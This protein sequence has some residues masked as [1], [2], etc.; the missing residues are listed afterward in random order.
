MAHKANFVLVL[1]KFTKT[2]QFSRYAMILLLATTLQLSAR[3]N[4]KAQIT[5]SET[6]AP[7][8]KIFNDIWKQTK[9]Q[10]V[11]TDK[12]L[13]N[14]NPVTIHVK[15]AALED[16]LDICFK[17]Q[18]FTY[19]ITD[20]A[21]VV[22]RKATI[23]APTMTDAAVLPVSEVRGF[24]TDTT[25][26]G[27]ENVAVRI[28]G[29]TRGTLTG[30]LGE[31]SL[32]N[33]PNDAVLE[34][35]YIGMKTQDVP[36]NSRSNISVTL[37]VQSTDLNDVVI[38]GYG[39]QRKINI[40]GAVGTITGKELTQIPVSNVSSM[41]LGTVS[42]ITGVQASGEPGR[43]SASIYIRGV[44]TYGSQT[45]LV[46]IDGVQQPEE[47]A[48]NEMNNMDAND[49]ATVSILKDASATAV[50]GIRGANGVIIITTKRGAVGKPTLSLSV[51][52]GFTQAA[53]LMK[54]VNSYE[55]ALM[56]NQ[57]IK[58]QAKDFGDNS[59]LAYLFSN[60]D[61]WKFQHNRD[62]TP[63][64][65]SAMNLTD[66]QKAQLNAS[67][68]IYY[69]SVD[70]MQEEFGGTGPQQQYNLN[71][72][73]GTDH[74]KYYTSLGYFGQGSI[75]NN[76]NYAGSNTGSSFSRYN[77]RSN[78]DINVTRDL[79]VSVNMTGE[80]GTTSGPG[81][82]STASTGPYD[83]TNRYKA[84]MQYIFD[85]NPFYSPGLIDGH[86]INYFEGSPGTYANPLGLK[87]GASIG[88]QNPIY[89]LL[90][91]GSEKLYST[92]LSSTVTVKYDLQ[93]VT[94]G[95]SA[96][97]STNYQG[98]YVKSVSYYPSLPVY[99]V[100]R[101]QENPNNLDFFNGAVGANN[102]N[103]NPGHNS[104]WYKMYYEGGL[105]YNRKFGSHTVS[106]LLLGTAQKYSM[107]SDA[108]NTPSGLM[109][110]VG[111]VTYNYKERYLAEANIGYNGTEQF[112]PGHRFGFFPA[113]SIGWIVT[114]EPFLKKN[115]VLTYLKIRG[116]YGEVGNDQLVVNG[117]TRRY[118]YL[119]STF[120]TGQTGYY[121]GNSNGSV[122][123]PYYSG[124]TEGTIG[125]PDV[126]WERSKKLDVGLDAR[127]F[128]DKLSLTL[129]FFKENRSNILTD[130]QTIPAV[131]GVPVTAVPPANIGKTTN[132]GYEV[133]L[134]WTDKIGQVSYYINGSV[135]YAKNKI[136]YEAENPNPYP[137]MNQTGHSIGQY[138]GLVSDGFYN[139]TEELNNRP[140]NT[141]TNNLATLGDIR[142]KDINGDGIIDNK[143]EVPI[144][145]PN[146]PEFYFN[147]KLGAS[148]KGFDIAILFIGSARGSYYLPA[149]LTIPFY[150]NAGNV[151]KWEYDGM[152]T[153]EKV[154]SGQKITYPRPQIGADPTSNN[155]LTSDFWLVS[156]N[157]KRL[158]NLEIGYTISKHSF[159]QHTVINAVRFYANSNNLLTWG[160]ALKGLDPQTQDLN[161]PYVYPMTRIISFGANI[162]F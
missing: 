68:A 29:T 83:M 4:L 130:I 141:F 84:I 114:N 161:S 96:H 136:L 145:Y 135:S 91:S 18:P 92:L 56:R 159:L 89:N 124:T 125:N 23:V 149:G 147:L 57:A 112:A 150:K 32:M 55:Y 143:D 103:T 15:N 115:D 45:P 134:G 78:F 156:N 67:P 38:V 63:A 10:F 58:T 54:T 22:R 62:Y 110:F 53:S 88:N 129:D 97:V 95:L 99:S 1:R 121:W 49:I 81:A 138:F 76:T 52:G 153:P 128:K 144:G 120:N 25:G 151:M 80:F 44:S 160:N 133:A 20:N 86:L 158:S 111:R 64:E 126:T 30:H 109:G 13:E 42:G 2:L 140:Y 37:Y 48:F 87:V 139:T 102:F 8:R 107:S 51:N 146:I 61:I 17:G 69:G 157:F 40:T 5:L 14:A 65:V 105:D 34:F 131:Y 148:Y 93:D 154:A 28:K 21:I 104:S 24:V 35:S 116:S 31:Y 113:Y 16:V 123:N 19:V 27:I 39:T 9:Q 6:N 119:P 79:L 12:E 50:Y 72:T 127:F 43:N 137:W 77:F 152:W 66:A 94:K 46:V 33:V 98:E 73:G 71:I 41:I 47:N 142:Y 26:K 162:Q 132:Q 117:V 74:I 106:G 3:P 155:F 101:N 108:Y 90:T 60:D 118:L 7:I 100:R 85:A 59:Y 36:V 70:W 11:F 122:Q 82:A 75:L